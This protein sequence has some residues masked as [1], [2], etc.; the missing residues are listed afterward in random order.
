MVFMGPKGTCILC[1]WALKEHTIP[2]STHTHTIKCYLEQK[3]IEVPCRSQQANPGS[4]A[5][6]IQPLCYF[7]FIC[8][9]LQTVTNMR[10]FFLLNKHFVSFCR[11][12]RELFLR[13]ADENQGG[14]LKSRV[15]CNHIYVL[16]LLCFQ[17]GFV[18]LLILGSKY[19][20]DKVNLD[21]VSSAAKAKLI[22]YRK[23]NAQYL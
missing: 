23:A 19:L 22:F 13:S 18:L 4:A 17:P 16:A 10:C 20:P 7:S 3:M 1:V 5:L 8:D 15:S 6:A 9:L 11:C 21:L 2:S 14:S 12:L